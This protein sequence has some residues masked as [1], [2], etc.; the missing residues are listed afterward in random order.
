MDLHIWPY[1]PLVFACNFPALCKQACTVFLFA[2]S[3]CVAIFIQWGQHCTHHVPVFGQQNSSSWW[4]EII[5][6]TSICWPLPGKIKLT[7]EFDTL[8][9]QLYVL[10]NF[11][12]KWTKTA[13]T[14]WF[15][16]YAYAEDVAEEGALLMYP[17]TFWISNTSWIHSDLCLQLILSLR[18]HI[19]AGLNRASGH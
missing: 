18:L 19:I 7:T 5:Q 11:Q 14:I 13:F 4:I 10:S 1:R 9:I 12:M 8:S 2:K 17:R 3:K 15:H 16:T 6:M